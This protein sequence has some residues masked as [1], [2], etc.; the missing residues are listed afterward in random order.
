M[1]TA[2]G[3]ARGRQWSRIPWNEN[4][5]GYGEEVEDNAKLPP[6]VRRYYEH[7]QRTIADGTGAEKFTFKGQEIYALRDF[8]CVS[9]AHFFDAQGH[10]LLS[11]VDG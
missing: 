2:T 9:S 1:T 4:G 11:I 3:F 5:D 10:K 6:A 7:M 8:S